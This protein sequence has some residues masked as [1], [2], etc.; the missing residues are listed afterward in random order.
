MRKKIGLFPI[1]LLF[2]SLMMSSC[3]NDQS[4][5]NNVDEREANEIVVYLASKGIHAIKV[6]APA[7]E[8][9]GTAST[10]YNIHVP[11]NRL[12]ESMAY[13]NQ[14]GLPRQKGTSI[15]QLFAK[16]GLVSSDKEEEIRYNAG[17]EE[18]LKNTI[19]KMDGVLDAEVNISFPMNEE[20]VGIQEK[21]PRIT[22]AVFVKHQGLLDDP[23]NHFETKIKRLLSGSI[24]NL[25]Y[26]DVSVIVDKARF[27]D[28]TLDANAELISH[29]RRQADTVSIWS[30]QM[31]KHSLARFRIIFFTFICIILAFGALLG[32]LIF[33]FYPQLKKMGLFNWSLP[34]QSKSK[35]QTTPPEEPGGPPES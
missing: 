30:I 6:E 26:E 33:K 10:F 9:G 16:S 31:S 25:S 23:N 18:Q 20:N 2:I 15:L 28:I 35:S 5:V 4:V 32:L 22:A 19:R 12:T 7:A 27:A 13:L 8:I 29:K 14:V 21:K 3:E 24:P 34:F 11:E 17:L 1:L